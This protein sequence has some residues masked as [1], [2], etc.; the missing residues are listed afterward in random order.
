M[1]KIYTV[2]DELLVSK[3]IVDVPYS[4]EVDYATFSNVLKDDKVVA[5]YKM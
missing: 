4:N 3:D 1:S 5:S 2:D